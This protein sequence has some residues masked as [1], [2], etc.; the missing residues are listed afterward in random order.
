MVANFSNLNA[1]RV[2]GAGEPSSQ[3]YS[4]AHMK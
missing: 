3:S 2:V 4:P 1:Y